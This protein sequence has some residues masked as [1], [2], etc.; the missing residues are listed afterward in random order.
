MKEEDK[1][2]ILKV[3][4]AKY[5]LTLEDEDVNNFFYGYRRNF[6]QEEY[7]DDGVKCEHSSAVKPLKKHV[8]P[9]DFANS[10]YFNETHTLMEWFMYE[11]SA[12]NPLVWN[13]IGNPTFDVLESYK[14]AREASGPIRQALDGSLY[15][16]EDANHRL[17]TLI[18]NH[19]LERKSAQTEAK[20]EATDSKY[21]MELEVSVPINKKLSELLKREVNKFECFDKTDRIFP[22]LACEFRMATFEKPR[23]AF[24]A[25]EYDPETQIFTY[26]LNGERFVGTEQEL[27]NFLL[28]KE[29]KAEP[30]MQWEAEGVYYISC[31]NKIY[32]SREKS[33]IEEFYKKVQRGYKEDKIEYGEFLEIKDIDAGTYDIDFPSIYIDNIEEAKYYA[34]TIR[35]FVN[36]EQQTFFCKLQNAD[37]IKDRINENIE[38]AF[39]FFG[40]FS[41][42]DLKYKGLT[43]EEYASVRKIMFALDEQLNCFRNK[44]NEDKI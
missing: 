26:N 39:G 37:S 35:Y 19:F 30:I 31:H 42:P 3:V 24:Y 44:E 33:T 5:G 4:L 43:K 40:G 28:T 21:T 20:R 34:D 22:A 32:K 41:M 38:K 16:G 18:I 13:N 29:V 6:R 17:L 7:N 27:T 36:N 23:E 10:G 8:T 11:N 15:N 9:L 12:S 25:A 1:L 2:N 14:R